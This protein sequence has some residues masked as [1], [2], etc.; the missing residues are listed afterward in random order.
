M[1][2]TD[3]KKLILEE[4]ARLFSAKRFDEV[5]MDDIAHQAGVG[6]GTIYT[7]FADKEE[8]YFAVVFEG[9]RRLNEQLQR[10][11]NRQQDPEEELRRMVH[12]I[13]SYFSQNRFFFR[14]MSHEDGGGGKGENRRRW[15]EE[16][17]IQRAAIENVLQNGAEQGVFSVEHPQVEAAILRGMVRSV[18]IHAKGLSVEAMVDTIMR[19]FLQ[20]VRKTP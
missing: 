14:L 20:G 4:A 8:L 7:H 17:R 16:R 2:K 3:R 11:A 13:V 9:I 10:K 12:A 15:R 18:M 5:L 1:A 6:K 19:I